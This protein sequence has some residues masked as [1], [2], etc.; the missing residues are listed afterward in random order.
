MFV[1]RYASLVALV[2]WLGG[3]VVVTAIVAPVTFGVLQAQVPG[4]GRALAGGVMTEVFRRFYLVA[5]T[6]GALLV[7]SFMLQA[8]L[9]P[10]PRSF[11]IR[12]GIAAVM[13]ACTVYGGSVIAPRMHGLRTAV[14]A[15]PAGDPVRAQFGKLHGISSTL[16]LATALGGLILL[17]WEAREGW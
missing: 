9:G 13:L 15:A 8:V 14:A 2:V 3:I 1:L 16:M 6:C 10:R 5:L 7:L 11:G 4:N 17:F 12:V